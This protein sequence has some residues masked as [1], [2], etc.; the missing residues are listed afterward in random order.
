LKGGISISPRNTASKGESRKGASYQ[1]R[2]EQVQH[3]E[4]S[5][6]K[7]L[8]KLEVRV[9]ASKKAK[10]F[11]ARGASKADIVRGSLKV[12]KEKSGGESLDRRT[13]R[14]VVASKPVFQ[15]M[16][17]RGADATKDPGGI[18]PCT[19]YLFFSNHLVF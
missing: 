19:L 11:E 5:P 8:K 14:K 3:P 16:P 2:Q 7:K 6:S 18:Y 10:D 9:D 1:S 17:P 4:A 12:L 13:R 15:R